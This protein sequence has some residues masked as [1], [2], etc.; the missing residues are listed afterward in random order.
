MLGCPF[1]F[2]VLDNHRDEERDEHQDAYDQNDERVAR[3][4]GGV[5]PPNDLSHQKRSQHESG[6]ESEDLHPTDSQLVALGTFS[7]FDQA[8]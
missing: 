7:P 8:N 4:I 2:L 1:E 6:H 3:V 5:N